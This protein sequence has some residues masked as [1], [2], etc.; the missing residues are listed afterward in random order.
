MKFYIYLWMFLL[1]F[2]SVGFDGFLDENL[3]TKNKKKLI[4]IT[5]KSKK[6]KNVAQAIELLFQDFIEI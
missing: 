2:L 4:N 5:K 3:D 6:R 1:R